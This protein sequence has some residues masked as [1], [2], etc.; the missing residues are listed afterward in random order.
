MS[1]APQASPA[2][3]AERINASY[4]QSHI[5]RNLDFRVMPG[6]TVSLLGRNGMGKTTLLRTLMGLLHPSSGRIRLGGVDTAGAVPFDVGEPDPCPGER[7]RRDV[8]QPL[9]VGAGGDLGH[10]PAVGVVQR[11]LADDLGGEDLGPRPA[12]AGADHRGGGVVAAALD[13]EDHAH[14]ASLVAPWAGGR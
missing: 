4:G 13:A 1:A 7:R 12:G 3:L 14:L 2:L 6:E 5:L 8:V 10:D 9:G 11:V